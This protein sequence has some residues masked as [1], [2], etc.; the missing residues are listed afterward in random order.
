MTGLR[1]AKDSRLDKELC[2]ALDQ[3]FQ[4][5]SVFIDEENMQE[6]VETDHQRMMEKNMVSITHLTN[7]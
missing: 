7:H 1:G 2:N 5:N 6:Q 3:S 4:R